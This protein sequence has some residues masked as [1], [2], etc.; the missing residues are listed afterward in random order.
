MY[1]YLFILLYIFYI[2]K[3][4]QQYFNL[5]GSSWFWVWA[6][7]S[8]GRSHLICIWGTHALK[9]T[10]RHFKYVVLSILHVKLRAP[11]FCFLSS[12][13][14]FLFSLYW[15][16]APDCLKKPFHLKSRRP[17]SHILYKIKRRQDKLSK[18]EYMFDKCLFD[19]KC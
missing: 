11:D 13:V 3:W 2:F 8:G 7:A 1:I 9:E 6:C 19:C 4:K 12:F 14:A 10:G 16:Y 17:I 5:K 15:N 18:C